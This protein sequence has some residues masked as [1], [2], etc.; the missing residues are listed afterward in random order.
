MIAYTTA[1]L[2][3]VKFECSTRLKGTC[4]TTNDKIFQVRKGPDFFLCPP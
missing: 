4:C 1:S 2:M 3:C